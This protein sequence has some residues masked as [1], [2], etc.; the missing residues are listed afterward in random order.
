MRIVSSIILLS[1]L[2]P[3][4]AHATPTVSISSS[5]KAINIAN[6]SSVTFSG[7]CSVNNNPVYLDIYDNSTSPLTTLTTTCTNR[8]WSKALSATSYVDGTMT[9]TARFENQ[10]NG[11]WA[12][13]ASLNLIKITTPVSLS[14]GNYQGTY[15]IN[16]ANGTVVALAGACSVNNAV[17][18]IGYMKGTTFYSLSSNTTCLSGIYSGSAD[19]TTL[20]DG[21][22]TIAV[23]QV[24]AA[25]NKGSAT[26]P[27]L[28]DMV[29]PTITMQASVTQLNDTNSSNVSFS[30]TCSANGA[31]V[32]FWTNPS[33]PP[34]NS[35]TCQSGSWS[36]NNL[37]FSSFPVG[38]INFQVNITDA[39]G[40][41]AYANLTILRTS[42]AC[43]NLLFTTSDFSTIVNGGGQT[44]CLAGDIDFSYAP[45][46]QFI[47]N[48][49]DNL[50]NVTID[51]Q[52]HRLAHLGAI[53]MNVNNV[54]FKNMTLDNLGGGN[55]ANPGPSGTVGVIAS[56]VSGL[57]LSNVT[58]NV[59]AF[60]SMISHVVVNGNNNTGAACGIF[61]NV[62]SSNFSNVTFALNWLDIQGCQSAGLI[63]SLS[64]STLNG[65]T[66]KS[67][68]NLANNGEVS[69]ASI[70]NASGFVGMLAGRIFSSNVSSLTINT[71]S[72]IVSDPANGSLAA[73]SVTGSATD[74]TF[75]GVTL[76]NVGLNFQTGSYATGYA[77]L[78]FGILTDCSL[79]TA[80]LSGS[81]Y[82]YSTSNGLDEVGSVIGTASSS[83]MQG[84]QSSAFL[85][86]S[87]GQYSSARI[88]GLIGELLDLSAGSLTPVNGS[89]VSSLTNSSDTNSIEIPNTVTGSTL[90][91]GAIG[92]QA[93]Q[94]GTHSTATVSGV[95]GPTSAV[96]YGP[97]NLVGL[98]E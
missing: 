57:T 53:A 11:L 25:G 78:A 61:G 59:D 54:T 28:K 37:N 20:P 50:N 85:Y 33:Q 39:G 73:G 97:I 34:T 46:S 65:I 10:V 82:Y 64:G 45:L 72:L 16:I 13:P 7:N 52:T 4:T 17:V 55:W 14:I 66:I 75:T 71:G 21:N 3:I 31:L 43:P 88:G 32:Q 92:F 2:I 89:T 23:Q 44:Y 35:T 51:G 86:Y 79:Q 47:P 60:T 27:A 81:V 26:L 18:N 67:G 63:G 80:T 49:G 19:Y 83:N 29:A 70:P 8:H 48:L 36:I 5:V 90:I 12:T 96:I 98:A 91:G 30:G 1:I 15:Y 76:T 58:I 6:S 95:T 38:K 22:V 77:G 24:D 62:S 87:A 93:D 68:N 94:D 40:N 74:S 84:V 69:F 41:L 9:F 56:L 42:A